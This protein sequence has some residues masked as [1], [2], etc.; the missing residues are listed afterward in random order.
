MPSSGHEERRALDRE[1]LGMALPSLGGLAV[2][3]LYVLTDTAII[4]HLGTPQ[5]GGAALAGAVL[6]ML[7]TVCNFLAYATT[8]LVARHHGAGEPRAVAERA[9]EAMVLALGLGVLLAI[10]GIAVAG[11]AVDVLGA[12]DD[13]R[14]HALTYLRISALGAPAV[15]VGLVGMGVTRGLQDARTGLAV[16]FAANAVNLVLEIVF[17]IVLDFGVAGSAWSTV[18]SQTGSGIVFVV[19]VVRVIRGQGVSLRPALAPLR[20]FAGVGAVLIARTGALLVSFTVAAAMAARFGD[21]ALAAHQIAFQLML[22]LALSLDA[23]AIAGQAIT[24]RLLGAGEPERA[25]AAARRMVGWG[26]RAGIVA[27]LVVVALRPALGTAFT[28]DPAVTDRLDGLLWFVAA[29]QPVAAVVYVLDGVHIG[30]GDLRYLAVTMLGVSSAFV[31]TA[32]AIG[33]SDGGLTALWWAL[34]GLV[35]GRALVMLARFSGRAWLQVATAGAGP[36]NAA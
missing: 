3:P 23:I 26:V 1:I 22:F 13:V 8:A 5:L 2:E 14:P 20:R 4:G 24:G 7:F 19:L 36:P 18:I 35:V 12:S 6:T 16:A 10:V 33:A 34:T 25:R 9:A 21:D 31:V 28:D 32:L 15:L 11:P 29:I 27:A 17:V 30:A